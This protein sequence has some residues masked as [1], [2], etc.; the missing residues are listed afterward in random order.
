MNEIPFSNSFRREFRDTDQSAPQSPTRP[1]DAVELLPNSGLVTSILNLLSIPAPT[2]IEPS[3]APPKKSSRPKQARSKTKR[4]RQSASSRNAP[5][6]SSRQVHASSSHAVLPPPS[7]L[8]SLASVAAFEAQSPA[9]NSPPA[10]YSQFGAHHGQPAAQWGGQWNEAF[11]DRPAKRARSEAMPSPIVTSPSFD[12]GTRPATSYNSGW[13]HNVEQSIDRGERMVGYSPSFDSPSFAQRER[14]PAEEAELL[15]N[16]SRGGSVSS[17]NGTH[18]TRP[19]EPN[20]SSDSNHTLPPPLPPFPFVIPGPATKAKDDIVDGEAEPSASHSA[21]PRISHPKDLYAEGGLS[22]QASSFQIYT[23]PE[24]TTTTGLEIAADSD[25]QMTDDQPTVNNVAN[26][27]QELTGTD[28]ARNGYTRKFSQLESPQSLSAE[29]HED[30]SPIPQVPHQI[31]PT[32]ATKDASTLAEKSLSLWKRRNSETGL[33]NESQ[34]ADIDVR[35]RTFSVPPDNFMAILPNGRAQP[36]SMDGITEE[37]AEVQ[38]PISAP[39]AS[40]A[41]SSLHEQGIICPTCNFAAD[42]MSHK[43]NWLQCDGCDRWYHAACAGF[44]E[45]DTKRIDKY[46]CKGCKPKFGSTTCMS[47]KDPSSSNPRPLTSGKGKRKSTRVHNTVDYAGLN[48]G[49]LRTA[50]DNPE[51]HYIQPIKENNIDLIPENF[52]RMAPEDLTADHFEKSRFDEPIVIPAAL[53]PRPNFPGRDKPYERNGAE[54][55]ISAKNDVQGVPGTGDEVEMVPDDGQDKLDMV[56]PQGLTVRR[57]ANLFGPKWEIPVINVK[58]QEGDRKKWTVEKWADYYEAT[59][60]ST[61]ERII[62][63]VISLECSPTPLGRLI[64]RPKVVR[65][66][67]LQ[68]SVWPKG[69]TRKMVGF[70]VLMSVADCYTD[71]HIDFGGSSVY[72]HIVKGKKTFFF[73]PPTQSNLQK[74]Q[75]WN[76]MASQNWTWLP[77]QTK[78]KECYRVDLSEGDTM[79]IPSGWIHAVWTPEDSLVI[80]GNFLTRLN[81]SMQFKVAEVER[82]NKTSPKFKYPRFQKVM[83]YAV[84]QY[85]EEDPLP[86]SVRE[87]LVKGHQFAREKAIW[88][89][90]NKFGHNSDPGPE[91]YN[92]R[93][94][95][96]AELDGLPDMVSYIFRTVM[97]F[98]DRLEGITKESRKSVSDSIPKGRGEPLEIAKRFAMWTAWKRGNEGI[99]EWAHPSAMVPARP[100]DVPEKKLSDAQFKKLRSRT[101]ASTPDR[102]LGTKSKVS[103][104][105]AQPVAPST[106][107]P[108][109]LSSTPKTS[110]LGPR[111]TACDACRRRK[112]RCKHAE[113]GSVAASDGSAQFY[114]HSEVSPSTSTTGAQLPAPLFV[115]SPKFVQSFVHETETTLARPPTDSTASQQS[116]H[117]L[118]KQ[119][120]DGMDGKKGRSKACQSCRNSKRRCIHDEFGNIDPIKQN[121]PVVPRGPTRPKNKNHP[122]GEN[123]APKRVK[124]E[125]HNDVPNTYTFDANQHPAA[126]ESTAS[127]E[128]LLDPAN[129]GNMNAP[130]ANTEESNYNSNA[131]YSD[132]PMETAES[133]YESMINHTSPAPELVYAQEP[134]STDTVAASI[135]TA[136]PATKTNPE[137]NLALE[138]MATAADALLDP[139]LL[140]E[141]AREMTNSPSP[142]LE[143]VQGKAVPWGSVSSGDDREHMPNGWASMEAEDQP[144]DAQIHTQAIFHDGQHQEFVNHGISHDAFNGP[145]MQLDQTRSNSFQVTEDLDDDLRMQQIGMLLQQ[146]TSKQDVHTSNCDPSLEEAYGN[147]PEQNSQMS[148]IDPSLGEFYG[149]LVEQN[150]E[151]SNID[152]LLAG[153]YEQSSD[154]VQ[155]SNIDPSLGG[156]YEQ[157]TDQIQHAN[158][159]PSLE[160]A[161]EQSTDQS[162]HSNIDPSLEG[163]YEQPKNQIQHENID[164]SLGEAYGYATQQNAH[165][166]NIDP[167]LEEAYGELSRYRT[168]HVE[169]RPLAMGQAEPNAKSLEVQPLAE[170]DIR[171]PGSPVLANGVIS[172]ITPR[173][174]S[175]ELAIAA[176]AVA[177]LKR[178]TNGGTN[179]LSPKSNEKMSSTRSK[180]EIPVEDG[181]KAPKAEADTKRLIEQMRQEDLGLRRRRA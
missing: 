60:G 110:S 41:S 78:T 174:I 55:D 10:F 26:G 170:F 120:S 150:A 148:N 33:S 93:Y 136:M 104:S 157:S 56:I 98:M 31:H 138:A 89:E 99:P 59:A 19:T 6:T 172:P 79:L 68:D 65:D 101:A 142:N 71:F 16:F 5:A 135:E 87:I 69:E 109:L 81:Y 20:A 179:N 51:H 116:T 40:S 134:H 66:L 160:G 53:N 3:K 85:L 139:A 24:D 154:Q 76:M 167:S 30:R 62:R 127:L 45:T 111:R 96:R 143:V 105:V 144:S 112:M 121:E 13:G 34:L 151:M 82:V 80:G 146:E 140:E 61:G 52:P 108:I 83:W 29:N 77:G 1:T 90:F 169:T 44:T 107:A 128:R 126:S 35:F 32:L 48:E 178:F 162:Q 12:N 14:D 161:Y 163:A 95:A 106:D 42:S 175:P 145:S 176:D 168:A 180:T 122:T 152:P 75:E 17:R 2:S 97:I 25:V 73:I 39:L 49:V 115:P 47:V 91:N 86:E 119:F 21:S 92:A 37:P 54:D 84:L 125:S 38:A 57:V 103:G 164:P 102:Q 8:D 11:E 22:G 156:A 100:E 118:M 181:I 149:D 74:Y 27:V 72:Y 158:I 124:K 46:Y 15:L 36:D 7:P 113:N 94:Y 23:P 67:D 133:L 63:N 88:Q 166:S 132:R 173:A 9:F 4:V 177:E 117:N 123:S 28:E 129:F 155:H 114:Q 43:V 18:R 58:A 50:D 64:R 70:Y 137:R 171:R 131:W 147:A 141:P 153:R 159:D 165:M 130:V